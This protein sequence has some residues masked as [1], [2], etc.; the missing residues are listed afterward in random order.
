MNANQIAA[1]LHHEFEMWNDRR[2]LRDCR[3]VESILKAWKLGR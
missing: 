2:W 3:R 1:Q